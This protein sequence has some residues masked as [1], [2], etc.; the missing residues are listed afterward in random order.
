MGGQGEGFFL[1]VSGKRYRL[2]FYD[3]VRLSQEIENELQRGGLF[4]ESNL[5]VVHSVTRSDMERAA[6]V[7]MKSGQQALLVAE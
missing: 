5:V 6:E 4:F 1:L 7:L 3:S 2:N